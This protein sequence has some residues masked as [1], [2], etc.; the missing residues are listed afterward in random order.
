MLDFVM[1]YVMG[2]HSA[3]QAAAFAR[4]AAGAAGAV[5]SGRIHDVD[6]RVDRLLLVVQAMWSLLRDAGLTDEEL[7]ARIAELDLA[8]GRADGQARPEPQV[9]PDCDSK[10]PAGFDHC[11]ICGRPVDIEPDPIGGI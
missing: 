11:Q 4:G 2:H 8:D 6:E 7:A 9:C 5:T 3:A 10:I 1:G